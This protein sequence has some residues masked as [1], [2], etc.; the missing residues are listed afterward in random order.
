MTH[1]Q[2]SLVRP[3]PP[4]FFVLS[5]PSGVGKDAVLTLLKS[6]ESD[7]RFIITT[8]TRP[9]RPTETD[10]TDYHFTTRENFE[11]L[12]KRD[13]LL[14]HA[15]VYGHWYGVPKQ[16]VRDALK[17]GR[18]A[19]VKVDVQGAASIK[20]I[21]PGAV[22]IFLMPPSLEEL[23]NRLRR[24]YTEKPPELEIRLKAAAEEIKHCA[25]FD[26]VVMNNNGGLKQAAADIRAI[27]T[28]EKCRVMPRH[29]ALP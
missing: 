9:R 15:N 22:F 14:E 12:L 11:K 29:I 10:G 7:I 18:D 19:M 3:H 4:Q 21:V 17:E 5:G 27:I 25:E 8:T 26:Y 20:K 6:T 2:R 16:T 23:G 24:R 1:Q 28:A 13:E